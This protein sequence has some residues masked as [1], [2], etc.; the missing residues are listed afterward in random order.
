MQRDLLAKIFLQAHLR[1]PL[2]RYIPYPKAVCLS[3]VHIYSTKLSTLLAETELPFVLNNPG[4]TQQPTVYLKIIVPANSATNTSGSPTQGVNNPLDNNLTVTLAVADSP[5][6]GPHVESCKAT[7]LAE[8][9]QTEK[10]TH[11]MHYDSPLLS[12]S[13]SRDGEDA[14]QSPHP[15]FRR[16]DDSIAGPAQYAEERREV[17]QDDRREDEFRHHGGNYFKEGE[18]RRNAEDRQRP[19]GIWQKLE[20]RIATLENELARVRAE[21]EE[22]KQRGIENSEMREKETEDLIERDDNIR[23]QLGDTTK[24]VQDQRDMYETKK[25][26]MDARLEQKEARQEDK[27]AQMTELRDMVQKIH[28]DME[29][30][31]GKCEDERRE[32]QDGKLYF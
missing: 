21:L 31:R 3:L 24:L 30:D 6:D 16:N 20:T 8:K 17:A 13:S 12:S 32:S 7:L 27:N 22:K 29:R 28:D 5:H 9:S 1:Y 10:S 4:T 25:A 19:D 15:E 11:P 14:L 2:I 18:E 23:A 26:L